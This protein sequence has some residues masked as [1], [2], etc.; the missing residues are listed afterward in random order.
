MTA[1]ADMDTALPGRFADLEPYALIWGHLDT[2]N[3]RYVVRQGSSMEALRAFH[4]AAAGRL[5]E[6]F[7]YL[8]GFPADD[9]PAPEARLFRTVMGLTEVSQA[10]EILGQPRVPHAPFPH[11]VMMLGPDGNDAR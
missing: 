1:S 11:E 6:I 9:L 10:I 8:D 2:Q 3:D 4:Q 5:E 7:S